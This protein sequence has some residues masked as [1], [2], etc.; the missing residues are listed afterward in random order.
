MNEVKAVSV[1]IRLESGEAG[2]LEARQGEILHLRLTRAYPPGAPLA[3]ILIPPESAEQA[4]L[5]MPFEAKALGSKRLETAEYAVRVRLR[6]L[7]REA[8]L[9]LEFLFP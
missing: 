6:N 2:W 5:E 7:R 4:A 1:A 8:R 3:F 9:L